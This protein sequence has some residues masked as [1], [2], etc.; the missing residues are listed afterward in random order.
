MDF[1]AF[2]GMKPFSQLMFAIFIMV[3]SV[4]VFMIAEMFLAIPFVGAENLLSAMSAADTD[5]ADGLNLLKY[6]QV[7]QSIGLFCVPP[8]VL[9]F[10][11]HGRIWEYLKLDRTTRIQTFLLASACLLAFI[12]A[13]NFLGELNSRMSFP[14]AL[15]GMETWMKDM[16]EGARVLTEKFMLVDGIPGLL[17]NVFMIAVLPAIGEELMFRGVV[18]NIFSRWTKNQHWGIW[19]TAFLFSAMHL[20]FYGFIPRF[21][22]GAMFG[23]LLVWTGSMWVPIIAHFVNNLMGVIGYFL[24]GKGIISKDIEEV[25]TGTGQIP[26]VIVSMLVVGGLLFLIYNKE[27]DKIK[28]PVNQVD[29]QA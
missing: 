18:Q 24:M 1:T 4:F 14:G 15:S 28:M 23:Y 21:L 11:Y 16:E 29:S 12:P 25:G 22:L 3:A 13:I 9:A 17:F 19:I 7:I 6:Y 27:G 20:Q 2:R 5:S 8:F 10:L 26:Y